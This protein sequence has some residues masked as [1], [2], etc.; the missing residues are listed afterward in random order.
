MTRLQCGDGTCGAGEETSCPRDCGSEGYVYIEPGTF[1]MGSPG[2]EPGHESNEVEH[3]VKLTVG[4]W[5]KAT[6][7]TQAEWREAMSTEPSYFSSCGEECPV[8]QVS[9]YDSV[10]YCNALS[11][12]EVLPQCYRDPDDGAAYDGLDASASKTPT[13]PDGVSCA[14][15]RLPTESE[16]EYAARA[17]TE[18]AFFNGEITETGRSPLDPKLDEIGWYGGNSSASFVGAYDCS[19][20]FDGAVKCGPQPVGGKP[21]NDWG[22]H[23]TAGN[24]WEWVWDWYDTYPAGTVEAPAEDPVG[25]GQGSFRVLRGGSWSSYAWYCRAANRNWSDP[26]G[27]NIDVGLRPVRS[28]PVP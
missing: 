18:T 20:W 24:V 16:W 28:V 10:A 3:E 7:V 14:G 19:G 4:F 1:T 12:K 17:G 9:W 26:G 2:T 27:R 6:E 5:M 11:A 23:D 15:Y 13:W 22:L 25:P 21:A 8:E